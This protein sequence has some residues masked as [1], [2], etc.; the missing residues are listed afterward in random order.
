PLGVGGTTSVFEAVYERAVPCGVQVG[1]G[2]VVRV[3]DRYGDLVDRTVDDPGLDSHEGRHLV[4]VDVDRRGVGGHVVGIVEVLALTIVQNRPERDPAFGGAVATG[5]TEIVL[6]GGAHRKRALGT[7]D[8]G[9]LPRPGPQTQ[10]D[11]LAVA[12]DGERIGS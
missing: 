7:R 5:L 6:L 2:V 10:C 8:H 4:A 9:S 1:I 11:V 3:P 12:A